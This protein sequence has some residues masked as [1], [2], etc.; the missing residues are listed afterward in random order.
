MGPNG[1][2]KALELGAKGKEVDNFVDKLKSEG[3][4]IMTS[5]SGKRGSDASEVLL[6]PVNVESVHVRVEEK[7]SLTCDRKGGLHNMK[8]QGMMT[9]RVTDDKKRL[10]R[11]TINNIKRK[12]VQLRTHFFVDQKLFTAESVIELMNPQMLFPL[13]YDMEALKWRLQTRDD[14]RIP[15]T[16]NCWSSKSE[17]G[18]DVT[19]EYELQDNRLEL[20]D[21]VISIPLPSGVGAP[22]IGNLDGEYRHD[23]RNVMEWRL[24]VI[25]ANNKTGSFKFSIAGEENDFFPINLSFV[26]NLNY[27][28]IQVTK[29]AD[30]EDLPVD[31]ST[32]TSCMV[33]KYEI[34]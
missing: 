26:C 13:N 20:N 12:G 10:I 8:V 33:D 22:V 19:I 31:F 28:D 21:V 15:L 11:L 4:T 32:E 3:E 7:I 14:A 6:P 25:D 5:T 16:I 1:P 29:V 24:P 18:C 34:L 27:C 23:S 17:T 30:D 2:N 9:V